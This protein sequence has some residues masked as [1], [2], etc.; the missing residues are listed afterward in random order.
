MKW[1]VT[2][3]YKMCVQTPPNLD[4]HYVEMIKL[5]HCEVLDK[6]DELINLVNG[7]MKAL[8]VAIIVI[9]AFTIIQLGVGI[10]LAIALLN[11]T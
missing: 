1:F 6:I 3:L 2:W 7:G 9:I 8:Y 5:Q 10:V 4:A 11:K